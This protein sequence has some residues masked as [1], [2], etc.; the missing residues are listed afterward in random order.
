MDSFTRI[1]ARGDEEKDNNKMT[2]NILIALLVLVFVG[3]VAFALLVL[4]RRKRRQ[5]QMMNE[6]LP[7]YHDVKRTG[8]HRRLTIQTGNGRSS[9]IVVDNNGQPMLANPQSPPHSPDNVPEIHITFPDEQDDQGRPKSGRVVVV[10]VGETSVG[11]EPLD[12]EQLPA[13]EK[14]SKTQFYSID[15]DKIG[16][17]KEKEFH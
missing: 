4:L 3:L 1:V 5:R 9:V 11:L 12:D 17:L 8:N 16:G 7:Q 2:V 10:R 13:Y 14:E 6:T 15:M